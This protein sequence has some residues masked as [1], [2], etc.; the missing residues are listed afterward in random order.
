[1]H[2]FLHSSLEFLAEQSGIKA[3]ELKIM[4]LNDP[5]CVLILP[6]GAAVEVS[7]RH[8]QEVL[9]LLQTAM[10]NAMQPY[11]STIIC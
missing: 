3:R 4:L 1:M 7:P 9:L 11:T 2:R 10:F 5:S 6:S 8:F